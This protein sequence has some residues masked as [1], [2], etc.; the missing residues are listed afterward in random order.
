MLI[1]V[2]FLSSFILHLAFDAIFSF[3]MSWMNAR[4]G[5]VIKYLFKLNSASTAT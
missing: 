3:D 5:D 2:K 4:Y 1:P